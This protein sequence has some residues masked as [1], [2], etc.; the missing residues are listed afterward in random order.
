MEP[1]NLLLKKKA[2]DT[3]FMMM[4]MMRVY[5]NYSEIGGDHVTNIGYQIG[6]IVHRL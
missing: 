3:R 6:S 1:D 2:S 5:F 4:T